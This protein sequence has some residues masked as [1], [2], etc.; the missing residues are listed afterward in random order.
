[1]VFVGQEADVLLILSLSL[2]SWSIF[3]R[4]FHNSS[5]PFYVCWF[6]SLLV[7]C[8]VTAH[9][10][11]VFGNTWHATGPGELDVRG[12]LR[13]HNPSC[14]SFTSQISFLTWVSSF[15]LFSWNSFILFSTFIFA[16]I[17][18]TVSYSWLSP[19]WSHFSRHETF[20]NSS[21]CFVKTAHYSIADTLALSVFPKP[22]LEAQEK[23][24]LKI[25]TKLQ[26]WIIQDWKG[27]YC[28]NFT[29]WCPVTVLDKSKLTLW[30]SSHKTRFS[31]QKKT[32]SK[33]VSSNACLILS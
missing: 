4:V 11:A 5:V 22:I 24:S 23:Y 10:S 30:L 25:K 21:K 32:L 33:T 19:T 3:S 16:P 17:S 13:S 12:F 20:F 15:S 7:I 2:A 6:P 26:T 9:K 29:V 8:G 18:S 27:A 31:S 1:M 14:F 28:W